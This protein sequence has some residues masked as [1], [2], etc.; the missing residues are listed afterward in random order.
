MNRLTI[1]EKANDL[2]ENRKANTPYYF[3]ISE[4]LNYTERLNKLIVRELSERVEGINGAPRKPE[5]IVAS[6]YSFIVHNFV[7]GSFYSDIVKKDK[8]RSNT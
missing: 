3:S 5:Y 4:E 7:P 2:I 8:E 6:I 1:E